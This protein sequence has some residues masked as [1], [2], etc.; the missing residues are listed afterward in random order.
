MKEIYLLW[1][2]LFF[3]F[4]NANAE[5]L[6]TGQVS[7]GLRGETVIQG[8]I[9]ATPCSIE[10]DSQYQYINY[11][12]ISSYSVNSING[13]GYNRK[14]LNIKMNSCISEYDKNK[15]KGINI[16][17]FALQNNDTD[18]FKLLGPKPGVILYIYDAD[19]NQLSPNKKYSVSESTIYYDN[20]TKYLFLKYKT[21]I[22][23]DHNE[24]EP[25]DYFTTINFNVSY[26]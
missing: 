25:G 26:D 9:V 17:F 5:N 7:D 21:E 16:Q 4:S 23:T 2:I 11:D 19:D 3:N 6:N 22:R 12:Y 13:K 20:K 18:G 24:V 1:A 14:P 8:Y 10:T 15:N